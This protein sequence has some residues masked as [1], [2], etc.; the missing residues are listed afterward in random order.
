MS[1]HTTSTCHRVA[2]V[3]ATGK[4][5]PTPS[6]R[7]T[8]MI[9]SGHAHQKASSPTSPTHNHV[10]TLLSQMY[11]H[12]WCNLPSKTVCTPSSVLGWTEDKRA[13]LETQLAAHPELGVLIFEFSI[14]SVLAPFRNPNSPYF[15]SVI[16]KSSPQK[17]MRA[18]RPSNRRNDSCC[19]QTGRGGTS[20]RCYTARP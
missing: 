20:T 5:A 18:G 9:W 1:E 3:G 6:K 15:D 8:Y 7:S 14:G 2:I 12:T 13:T 11:H 17:S 10:W 16:L 4:W 19:S